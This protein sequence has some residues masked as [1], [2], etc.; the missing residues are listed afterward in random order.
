MF[1]YNTLSPNRRAFIDAALEVFPDLTNTITSKQI[2]QVVKAKSISYPQW[3]IVE[4]N[5]ESRGVYHF[6]NK[7][8]SA[9]MIEETDKEIEARIKERFDAI[10][11]CVESAAAGKMRSIILS[12]PP[13]VGKSH[14]VTKVLESYVG[15]NFVFASGRAA[16]TGLYKLLYDNR[17]PNSVIVLDDIDS[18]F[19]SVDAL[20]IL[21]KA[22]D[23]NPVRRIS[24][25]TETKFVSDEDGAEIPKSFDFEGSIV[26]I[27]NM[28]FDEHI[29]RGSKMTPH[30]EALI[31]RSLY[32]NLGLKSE[33][34]LIIRIKQVLREG[35]LRQQNLTVHEENIIVAFIE[36]NAKRLR[37]L[38]LRM[39]ANLGDIYK[40]NPDNFESIARITCFKVY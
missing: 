7:T 15:C 5:R 4:S 6:P 23:R 27:T 24:W 31:S 10:N 36:H 30:F 2:D 16:A 32:I 25:L 40:M 29:N 34:E 38:S 12:G 20:N 33:R 35:M 39:C 1:D 19:D 37:E 17:F 22:C 8:E 14:G 21:K 13:G 3:F 11:L 9:P 26:F 28:D 18:V